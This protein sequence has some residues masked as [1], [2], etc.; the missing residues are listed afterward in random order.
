MKFFKRTLRYLGMGLVVVGFIATVAG[1]DKDG[2][3]KTVTEIEDLI[4][5]IKKADEVN[6]ANQRDFSNDWKIAHKEFEK[7]ANIQP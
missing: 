6:A 1:A 7:S 3:D 4:I 2:A 5:E